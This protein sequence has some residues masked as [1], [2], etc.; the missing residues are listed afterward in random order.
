MFRA[1][2]VHLQEAMHKRHLVYWVRV[3]SVGCARN[4]V[5]R[6]LH[7][8]QLHEHCSSHN[9]VRMIKSRTTRWVGHVERIGRGQVPIGFG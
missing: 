7:N 4:E 6:R 8:E 2:P 3:M 5:G 9:I 1:K